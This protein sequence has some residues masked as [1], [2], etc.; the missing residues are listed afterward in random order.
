VTGL[1]GVIAIAAGEYHSVALKSDGTVWAWGD[2]T[3]GQIGDST[4]TPGYA[5]PVQVTGVEGDG[6]L[7]G[8]TTI[9]VGAYHNLARKSDGTVYAW[10]R[11]EIQAT[12]RYRH[13]PHRLQ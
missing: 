2:N 3:Y 11:N 5:T 4:S 1:T 8:I 13:I 7:T 12:W 6:F 9:A 10:G